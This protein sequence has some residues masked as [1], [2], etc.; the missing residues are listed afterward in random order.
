LLICRWAQ[1]V[2]PAFPAFED[3]CH[4]LLV[5]CVKQNADYRERAGHV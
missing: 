3:F 5:V 4:R 2:S 1:A